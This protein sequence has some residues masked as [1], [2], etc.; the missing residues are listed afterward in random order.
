MIFKET[1]MLKSPLS[2]ENV[3]SLEQLGENRQDNLL[4]LSE[5]YLN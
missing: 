3:K 1:I 2:E 5:R 4:I